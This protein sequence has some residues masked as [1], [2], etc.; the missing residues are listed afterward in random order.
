MPQAIKTY[1]TTAASRNR[2]G[3]PK[4]HSAPQVSKLPRRT[5]SGGPCPQSWILK[6]TA[7][8]D[9]AGERRRC[10]PA[11]PTCSLRI[12]SIACQRCNAL[13]AAHPSFCG[14]YQARYC[15]VACRLQEQKRRLRKQMSEAKALRAQGQSLKRIAATVGQPLAIAK[16]WLRRPRSGKTACDGNATGRQFNPKITRE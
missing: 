1:V 6:H 4:R 14:A 11:S 10:L 16:A 5:C 3:L 2:A 15:S 9:R 13:P 8:S 7:P 12:W